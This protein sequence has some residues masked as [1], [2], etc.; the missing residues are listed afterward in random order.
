[1]PLF[2]SDG[3]GLGHVIVV[4]VLVLVF[5]FWSWSWSTLGLKN[6]VL[7]TSLHFNKLKFDIFVAY[8]LRNYVKPGCKQKGTISI[9][10]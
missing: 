7:F 1:M 10:R 4:L 6:L 2:T 5:L 9:G 3:L 8:S